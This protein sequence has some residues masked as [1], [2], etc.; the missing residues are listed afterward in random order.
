VEDLALLVEAAISMH[1]SLC[2]FRRARRYSIPGYHT[3]FIKSVCICD[4]DFESVQQQGPLI[5]A[6]PYGI[7]S[8]YEIDYTEHFVV[9]CDIALR[10]MVDKC[11]LVDLQVF[12]SVCSTTS[13]LRDM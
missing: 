1:K 7:R 13:S 8:S 4:R 10:T 3:H 2:Q 12:G 6:G 9:C 5:A 11:G